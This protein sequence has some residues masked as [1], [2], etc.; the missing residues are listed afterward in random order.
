VPLREKTI[1]LPIPGIIDDIIF[2]SPILLFVPY[3]M[4]MKAVL[5]VKIA[6]V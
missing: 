1:I 2:D 4:I 5:P 3:N 6:T